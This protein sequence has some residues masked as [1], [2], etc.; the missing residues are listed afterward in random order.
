MPCLVDICPLVFEKKISKFCQCIFVISLLSPVT[1]LKYYDVKLSLLGKSVALHSNKFE[2]PSPK[3]HLCQIWLKL[4]K[5]FWWIRI[6]FFKFRQFIF[7]TIIS[8]LSPLGKGRSRSFE[9]TWS[10]R[11]LCAKFAWNWP[12]GSGWKSEKFTT[13]TTDNGHILIGKAHLRLWL[14]WA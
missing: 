12:S 6:R 5:W 2:S 11:M 3:D 1:W 14:R 9:Q 7:A 8:L 10:P 13:T 4:V